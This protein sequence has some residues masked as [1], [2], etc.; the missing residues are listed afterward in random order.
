[1]RRGSLEGLRPKVF[2]VYK[3]PPVF[4]RGD[5]DTH[6]EKVA[7]CSQ[8]QTPG[9]ELTCPHLDLGLSLQD[10]EQV[11]SVVRAPCRSL[12]WQPSQHSGP[13]KPILGPPAR[14][15]KQGT[16]GDVS[17]GGSSGTGC[18]S[19]A[20]SLPSSVPEPIQAAV[21]TERPLAD[22]RQA[23]AGWGLQAGE[24]ADTRLPL[25]SAEISFRQL[26]GALG[27]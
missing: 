26:R 6:R 8:G 2:R 19:P 11:N 14:S 7:T 21:H 9:A 16:W 20:S 22:L 5:Q 25:P 12:L 27:S 1:M 3:A 4:L 24:T 17:R 18:G 15:G 13:L 23:R 10:P